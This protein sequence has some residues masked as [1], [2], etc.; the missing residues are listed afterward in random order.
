MV[1]KWQVCHAR[2]FS[3]MVQFCDSQP[4]GHVGSKMVQIGKVLADEESGMHK[5]RFAM[6]HM[7]L[8]FVK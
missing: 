3:C 7:L 4:H 2:V 8:L 5:N 6:L 1:H